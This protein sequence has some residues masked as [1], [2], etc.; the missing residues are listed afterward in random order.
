[1]SKLLIINASA[2]ESTSYSRKLA[3]ALEVEWKLIDNQ[4]DVT[5]RDLTKNPVPHIDESWIVGAFKPAEARTEI[6]FKALA[7]SDE[8]VSELKANDAIVIATPMY[9]WSVPSVLKAY[10]DQT[11]R[12]NETVKIDPTTPENPY[13][14]LLTNKKAFL[15][16]VRGVS[17]YE[18]GQLHEHW[19]FQTDYLRTVLNIMGI[20][21]I[22]V[23]IM[24]N[25][26]AGEQL[27]TEEFNRCLVEMKKMIAAPVN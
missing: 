24:N 15:L 4:V 23:V 13:K 5:H 17:G 2:R 27:A 9:N 12:V 6:D 1:M 22:E 26:A 8:L 7:V 11:I 25:A 20:T 21:D 14:G 18:K 10:I 16:L 3:E 19:N